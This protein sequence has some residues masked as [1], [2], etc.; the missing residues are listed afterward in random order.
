MITH[1]PSTEQLFR[2]LDST[3]KP[4]IRATVDRLIKIAN[5]Q[6]G[7]PARLRTLFLQPSQN[8]H[9]PIA[10][11]LGELGEIDTSLLDHLVHGLDHPEPDIRW[12]IALMLVRK[13]ANHPEITNRLIALCQSG[14]NNQKRMACYSLR[15]LRLTDP[16]SLNAIAEMLEDRDATNRVAALISIKERSEAG[17]E[18]RQKMLD[19]Y[20]SDSQ[21]KVRHTAAIALA[22]LGNPSDEFVEALKIAKRDGDDQTKKAAAAALTKLRFGESAPSVD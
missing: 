10:Y 4:T 3:D 11:V 16:A 21:T 13:A 7:L 14:T 20:L 19:L 22:T 5:D 18:I 9:W 2:D 12:A 17:K 8:D 15:D 1:H 6:P